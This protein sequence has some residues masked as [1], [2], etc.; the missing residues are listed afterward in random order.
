MKEK[1]EEV[2]L[3][4]QL[5]LKLKEEMELQTATSVAI[6]QSPSNLDENSYDL[7]VFYSQIPLVLILLLLLQN[8]K[9]L[10]FF[11]NPLQQVLPIAINGLDLYNECHQ[12]M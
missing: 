6:S 4:Y 5:F 9:Y 11:M 1:R 2:H 3:F 8:L 12:N 10:N 7:N